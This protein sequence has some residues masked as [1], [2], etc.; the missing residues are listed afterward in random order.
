MTEERDSRRWQSYIEGP[1]WAI[2][3]S[4][5]YDLAAATGCLVESVAEHKG[6]LTKTVTFALRGSS[7]QIDL[8]EKV[9]GNALA[10]YNRM[11]VA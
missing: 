3:V 9:L 10:E 11:R 1:R 2:G 5:I 6:L 7:S 8:A 4:T